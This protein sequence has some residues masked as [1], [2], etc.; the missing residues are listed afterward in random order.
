MDLVQT[1]RGLELGSLT[2]SG[3]DGTVVVRAVLSRGLSVQMTP[4]WNLAVLT[5]RGRGNFLWVTGTAFSGVAVAAGSGCPRFRHCLLEMS[6][7]RHR[8]LKVPGPP[9]GGVAPSCRS[10]PTS[11]AE[12][13]TLGDDLRNQL[14]GFAAGRAVADGDHA[15]ACACLPGL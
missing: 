2:C 8:G 10:W 5:G 1:R 13:N 15:N 9:F 6:R 4:G 7:V 12:L 11:L 14:L 3:L